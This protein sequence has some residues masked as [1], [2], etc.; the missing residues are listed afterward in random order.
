M[1]EV[2]DGSGGKKGEKVVMGSYFRFVIFGVFFR[3]YTLSLLVC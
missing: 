1:M 2:N 3:L